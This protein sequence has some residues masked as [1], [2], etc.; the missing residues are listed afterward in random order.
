MAWGKGQVY[1]M[2]SQVT[3]GLDLLPIL[4]ACSFTCKMEKCG[5]GFPRSPLDQSPGGGVSTPYRTLKECQGP[6]SRGSWLLLGR[7]QLY[8][9]LFCHRFT[10]TCRT[11]R[12]AWTSWPHW[13]ER[14]QWLCWRTWTKG[15]PWT[16]WW[17]AGCGRQVSAGGAL[18]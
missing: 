7:D 16:T 17:A 6:D 5:Y 4:Q 18:H 15:R 13:A 2:Q 3:L 1:C 10:R 9:H 11:S 8:V 14:G 12:N